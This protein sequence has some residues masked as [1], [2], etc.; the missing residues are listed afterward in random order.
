LV[1]CAVH[2]A[3]PLERAEMAREAQDYAKAAEFYEEYLR[4]APDE[5]PVE[6]AQFQVADI[7]FLKLKQHDRARDAYLAFL[8]RFPT[9]G[10][11]Y[12]ARLRLAEVYAASGNPREAISYY[13]GLIA[14]WPDSPDRRKLRA[15]IADLYYDEKAFSQAELEYSR[16]VDGA[17]YDGLT[18]R[19]LLRIA[20]INYLVRR[21]P[22]GAIP[23]Y[24]RVSTSTDDPVVRRQSLCSLSECYADL[25]RFDEAIATLARLDDPAEA[26]YVAGRTAELE[27]QRRS[28]QEA[29][30]EVDW[31]KGQGE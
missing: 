13:E 10:R 24:D 5:P 8:S 11:V 22:E 19:S 9:S 16:V 14:D 4:E 30:P 28:H 25:F 29:P 27:R 15:A 3:T 17:D 26:D 20:S 21:S 1:G 7:Y 18:E 2:G 31:S 12:D 6:A 23:L